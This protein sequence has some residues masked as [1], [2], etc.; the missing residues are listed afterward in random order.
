MRLCAQCWPE[1]MLSGSQGDEQVLCVWAP[2]QE[3]PSPTSYSALC[4]S[5]QQP[6][7]SHSNLCTVML[8]CD[9]STPEGLLLTGICTRPGTWLFLLAPQPGADPMDISGQEA[10]FP[11]AAVACLAASSPELSTAVIL[12]APFS[13]Q[14]TFQS[15]LPAP[16]LPHSPPPHPPAPLTTAL[17]EGQP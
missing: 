6:Q 13:E 2:E 11:L 12:R 14:S 3:A 5:P 7:T 9:S 16:P 17:E 1:A 15:P 8:G 10:F 4:S